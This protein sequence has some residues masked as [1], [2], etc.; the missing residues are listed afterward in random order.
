M[1][2]EEDALGRACMGTE[3]GQ[4]EW[5]S[6]VVL[7]TFLCSNPAFVR[8]RRV[9]ELGSGVGTCGM[10]AA[11]AGAA[12]VVFTDAEE[13]RP[14]LDRLRS[15]VAQSLDDSGSGRYRVRGFTWGRLPAFLMDPHTPPPEVLLAADCLY[16]S[17]QFEDFVAS[18]S[19]LLGRDPM[20]FLL[21]THHERSE[22]RNMGALLREYGLRAAVV[23]LEAFMGPTDISQ[24]S[25]H[26]ELY[27]I[28]STAHS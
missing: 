18:V 9:L 15:S 5:P 26:I 13:A 6:A 11:E 22:N 19:Y 28:T 16:D 20:S 4:H 17:S 23:P 12:E 1:E 10:A 27:I 24:L 21:M 3:T 25:A 8:G 2:E 7:K 14:V